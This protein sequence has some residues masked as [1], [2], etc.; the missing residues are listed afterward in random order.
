MEYLYRKKII[1][2]I[3][4][5]ITSCKPSIQDENVYEI[6]IRG[7]YIKIGDKFVRGGDIRIDLIAIET[8]RDSVLQQH[9]P[10]HWR[11]FSEDILNKGL[12]YC[13]NTL[14]GTTKED[15]GYSVLKKDFNHLSYIGG[16]EID[17]T[18]EPN[19]VFPRSYLEQ[20]YSWTID[21]IPLSELTHH[22][23]ILVMP[24]YEIYINDIFHIPHASKLISEISF[25][26]YDVKHTFIYDRKRQMIVSAELRNPYTNELLYKHEL[27]KV[28]KLTRDEFY[29]FWKEPDLVV[30]DNNDNDSVIW[31]DSQ[32]IVYPMY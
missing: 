22:S 7:G 8:E 11:L 4:L 17:L 1:I 9:Y 18:K 15:C 26:S 3:L 19:T 20:D 29:S 13:K 21:S 28:I 2:L 25:H 5:C 24:D 10:V 32:Y 27:I 30:P 12:D 31:D 6:L 14:I 23:V 16:Y